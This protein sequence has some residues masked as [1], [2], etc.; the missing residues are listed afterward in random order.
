MRG[1]EQKLSG[2]DQDVE[3]V[4][5]GAVE[6]VVAQLHRNERGVP[7]KRQTILIPGVWRD[8]ETARTGAVPA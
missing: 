4:G 2:I 3:A 5:A 6:Q 1:Q 7:A 8:G